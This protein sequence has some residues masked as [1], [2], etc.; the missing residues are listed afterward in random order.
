MAP[1]KLSDADKQ[2]IV[3]L[4]RNP[5]ETTADIAS[6]YGISTTTVSR[7]LKQGMPAEEYEVL[8]QQKRSM[9]RAAFGEETMLEEAEDAREIDPPSQPVPK[10]T[11]EPVQAELDLKPAV[12][13]PTP[14]RRR[15]SAITSES[16]ESTPMPVEE[17]VEVK[18]EL[19]EVEPFADPKGA[20]AMPES[21][22]PQVTALQEIFPEEVLPASSYD[23]D[24]L[25]DD[26]NDDLDDDLDDN[27]DDDELS[28]SDL[29]DLDDDFEDDLGG[30]AGQFDQLAELQVQTKDIV[31]VLPL[32]EAA[33]P[34]TFYLVVDRASELIT[35]PLRDFAEL[36][37]IP[38]E[39]V[40]ART[41][42]I[43]DNH[44]LAK[45]FL[46]R[47]QR[48]VKVPDGGRMLVKV[49]PYLQAKGI[50]RLLIDGQLYSLN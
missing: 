1:T 10:P 48:V 38:T 5:E 26:L 30:D 20:E 12:K 45:R 15:R 8:I 2:A 43:F 39:E 31:Q 23:E 16:L 44:R 18:A 9:T 37:Q 36:G 14:R 21:Y 42:P 17:I 33:I 25:G 7:V 11:P 32:S 47:S 41:L 27:L 40:Q 49:S 34:K 22:S 50:T 29:D 4:Y 13:P 24:D 6:R 28:D 19:A 3:A 35:R 46:R